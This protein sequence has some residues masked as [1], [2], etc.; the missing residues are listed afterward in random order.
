MSACGP[1]LLDHVK[2]SVHG[3]VSS[4][5]DISFGLH[6]TSHHATSL[7]ASTSSLPAT[8][9]EAESGAVLVQVGRPPLAQLV[10]TATTVAGSVAVL[11]CGP[12]AFNRDARAAAAQA[13]W[14]IA[15]G[16]TPTVEC[17]LHVEAF[18]W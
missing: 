17:A 3:L 7:L 1:A 13:Q 15:A 16:R 4:Q 18:S 14:E 5:P 12:D 10:R 2:E 8:K 9:V 6:L 11:A